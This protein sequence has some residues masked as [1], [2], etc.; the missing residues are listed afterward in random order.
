MPQIKIKTIVKGNR[1]IKAFN[2][3]TGLAHKGLLIN[4]A[5]LAALLCCLL[6]ITS[7]GD[8]SKGEIQN[9]SPIKAGQKLPR[10]LDLG[11]GTCIPCKMMAPILDELS[12]KYKGVFDVEFIDV[13]DEQSR[14]LIDLYRIRAIPTQIFL[15]SN[16]KK[17][18]RHEGFISKDDIL[19]KWKELGYSFKI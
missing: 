5:L 11:S 9:S 4:S 8:S 6:F 3:K 13:R 12:A 2:N 15:D 18:W 19:N 7:C 10:L 14:P 17:L 16:G 1:I